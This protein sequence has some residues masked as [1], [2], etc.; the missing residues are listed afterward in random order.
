MTRPAAATGASAR[1]ATTASPRS[2]PAAIASGP[3]VE[4]ALDHLTAL[5][6]KYDTR[7]FYL[8]Q[9][10]VAPK[11]LLKLAQGMAARGMN[12][13]WAT[14]LKPEN[15]LTEA[16][17]QTLRGVG[18]GACAVGVESAA[19]RVLELIDKGAPVSTVRATI[20]RLSSA[21]I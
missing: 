6:A 18:A 14:D 15:Y 3:P 20:Q 8:S 12:L 16:R 2:A 11:T 21:G 4:L 9:D 17:A 1:S 5:S 10:S 13:R 7:F 19:P